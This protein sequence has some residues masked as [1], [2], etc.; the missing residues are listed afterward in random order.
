MYIQ[1]VVRPVAQRKS[2]GIN[3]GREAARRKGEGAASRAM[4][5]I[6]VLVHLQQSVYTRRVIRA[7]C[8]GEGDCSSSGLSD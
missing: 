4:L 5:V 2:P 7:A 8:M 6:H 1:H 3:P